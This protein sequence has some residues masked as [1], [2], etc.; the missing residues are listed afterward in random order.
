MITSRVF[1][2][3]FAGLLGWALWLILRPFFGAILW[4][5]LLAFL[6]FPV[7]RRLRARL[8][9]RK[10]AAA[11]ILTF[12]VILGIVLP[13]AILT[14]AFVGQGSDLLARLSTMADQYKIAR[15]SDIL[16]V[17]AVDHVLKA[18][19]DR[20]PVT[21]DQIQQGLVNGLRTVVQFLM[22]S[23]RSAFLGALGAM[24][25]LALTLFLVYFFFRDGD[26]ATRRVIRMIPLQE[27]RKKRLVDHIA[28]VTRA[29]VLGTLVTA[30]AQGASIGIGFWISGLPSPVVFGVL[31]AVCALLPVGGTAFVWV[32]G[33][34]LLGAQGRWGWAIFL[35]VWGALIVGSADNVLRPLLISGRAQISTLAV[36]FG[37]LGGL[38]AFGMIGMF[39][40][41]V[42]IALALAVFRFAEEDFGAGDNQAEASGA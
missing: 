29:V 38:A 33:A 30:L 19:Q 37:V 23:G 9:G 26:D 13:A 18:I 22:T 40:G 34:L 42:L 41:P 14:V 36:F 17:P 32:P 16:H 20:I 8:K 31:A 10:G 27:G 11:L 2:L 28:A 12:A 5:L 15:P 3:V 6:L 21:T 1:G 7:N 24:V 39:L 25:S 4:A 35:A